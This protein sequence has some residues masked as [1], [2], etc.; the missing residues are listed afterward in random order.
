MDG[1]DSSYSEDIYKIDYC[2][3]SNVKEYVLEYQ[4]KLNTLKWI[5]NDEESE[6][7]EFDKLEELEDNIR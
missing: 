2:I 7:E 5:P 6:I 3:T 1:W 4:S